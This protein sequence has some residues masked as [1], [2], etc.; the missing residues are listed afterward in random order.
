MAMLIKVTNKAHHLIKEL[1]LRRSRIIAPDS[2]RKI[3]TVRIGKLSVFQIK[4]FSMNF[5]PY[6]KCFFL[7]YFPLNHLKPYIH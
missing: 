7:K 1:F 6:L 5:S 2:G 4:K 3:K